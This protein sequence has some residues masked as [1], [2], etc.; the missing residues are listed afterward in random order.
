MQEIAPDFSVNP[1]TILNTLRRY[2]VSSRPPAPRPHIRGHLHKNYRGARTSNGDGYIKIL[3]PP[4]APE[5]AV[6]MVTGR[7]RILEHRYVMAQH[8][9]RPLRKDENVHHINGKRDDN[10]IENLELWT[11]SQPPGQRVDEKLE[12]AIEFVRRYRPEILHED[13]GAG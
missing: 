10:R 13:G 4:D 6:S 9:G 7:N 5:W 2:G 3:L 11:S 12:W 8:L 1:V